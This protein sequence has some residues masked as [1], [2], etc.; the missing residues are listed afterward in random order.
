MPP[1]LKGLAINKELVEGL[2][3]F[4][5]FF[6][7]P[8]SNFSKALANENPECNVFAAVWSARYSLD[9]EI[10]SWIIIASN[11][12]IIARTSS[13]AGSTSMITLSLSPTSRFHPPL[14]RAWL[15]DL[16]HALGGE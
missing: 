13:S 11:G 3:P 5:G 1:A 15:L 12:V 7:I 4:I 6:L 8:S 2:P 14:V 10:A 9:L 16:Y